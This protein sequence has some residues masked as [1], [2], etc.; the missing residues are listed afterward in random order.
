M[1][2]AGTQ[3]VAELI[4]IAYCSA[5]KAQVTRDNLVRLLAKARHSNAQN[6]VTGMLLY[7]GASFFQVLEG[8]PETVDG[9]FAVISRD[10]RHARVTLIIREPIPRRAFSDWTMGFADLAPQDLRSIAGVNNFLACGEVLSDLGPGRARKLLAAFRQGRWRATLSVEA[11]PAPMAPASPA[12]WPCFSFAFQPIVNAATGRVFS[13]EALVRGSANEPASEV[14][15][16]V[17]PSEIHR[18]DERC[19]VAAV[20]LAARMGLDTRLDLNFLPQGLDRSPTA[21]SST[22]EAA[23]RCGIRPD[24]LVLE[25][26]ESEIILDLDRFT[27]AVNE[28]R[29][30]GLTFAIDDF[31]AGHAGLNL[32]ATFQP[33]LIKLDMHLVRGI[34][35][36]GP[37]QAIVRGIARTC[38]DLGIDMVAEGVETLDE[39][40][41]L[42]GEG[43]ELFQGRLLAEPAFECFP[44][45]TRPAR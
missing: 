15:R 23:S 44:G 11:A 38:L 28:H 36:H 40:E 42:S 13:Y 1:Q 31:G 17:D 30:T 2:G 35:R 19:R 43:V 45:A 32:L 21:V 10:P 22:L 16:Q 12:P 37:R 33:E 14:L 7:S 3:A 18:F 8:E 39:Y 4:Q 9:L 34:E 29:G 6:G 27:A 25:I 24:Q 41:W 5:A 20:E 26:L